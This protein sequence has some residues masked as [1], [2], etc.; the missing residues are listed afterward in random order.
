MKQ[1]ASLFI[2]SLLTFGLAVA[3][4]PA[5]QETEEEVFKVVE[6]MPRFPG[7]EGQFKEDRATEQCAK[8]KML[9]YIYDNLEYPREA[10][11]KS[12]QGMVVI[13]FVIQKDGSIAEANILRDVGA[14]LGQAALEVVNSMNNLPE[15]WTPGMQRGKPVSV[16]FTLPV[17]FKLPE[18]DSAKTTVIKD[19]EKEVPPPPPPPSKKIF[20]NKTKGTGNNT[21]EMKENV[22]PKTGGVTPPP[23]PPPP[24]EEEEEVFK[25]VE[26]MPM[27]PGC[28]TADR[29]CTKTKI[30]AYL[31]NN[32]DYPEEARKNNISGKVII[33][34]VVDKSGMV[35]NARVIRDIGGGCGEAAL[36]AVN[37]MNNLPN[38]WTPGKQRGRAV[39]VFYTLPVSFGISKDK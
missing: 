26:Q 33:Q 38:P 27:F 35:E 12:V 10:L 9:Q 8:E 7:C 1:I 39:K 22:R 21:V 28:D 34:F 25:I 31:A 2:F 3:Q 19:M 5:P 29:T 36:K 18:D 37:E 30:L 11:K 17:K 23:P 6:Q 14:N 4:S 24:F 15:R 13:Q 20:K 32:L 16:L